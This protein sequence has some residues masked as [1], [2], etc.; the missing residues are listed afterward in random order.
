MDL[1]VCLMIRGGTEGFW[2]IVLLLNTAA[3]HSGAQQNTVYYP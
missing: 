2:S 3:Y 1:T